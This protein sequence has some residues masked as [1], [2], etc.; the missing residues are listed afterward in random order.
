[1][2]YLV[3]HMLQGDRCKGGLPWILPAARIGVA[4]AVHT[5][6]VVRG[7]VAVLFEVHIRRHPHD[8]VS[9]AQVNLQRHTQKIYIQEW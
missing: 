6:Y 5:W 1:M 7:V 8:T 3:Q 9:T 4:V 2:I